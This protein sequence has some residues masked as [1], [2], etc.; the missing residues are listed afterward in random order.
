MGFVA[1]KEVLVQVLSE[2][3]V[4]LCQFSFHQLLHVYHLSS[5]AG[6]INQ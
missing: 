1:D 4:F 5:G 3:F 2:Y 6:E